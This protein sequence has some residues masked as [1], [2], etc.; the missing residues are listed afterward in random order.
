MSQQSLLP[1]P[2]RGRIL[3]SA[4]RADLKCRCLN[5]HRGG[6]WESFVCALTE[7]PL[8][9]VGEREIARGLEGISVFV[10]IVRNGYSRETIQEDASGGFRFCSK[11]VALED[12]CRAAELN[13]R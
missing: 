11:E 12:E 2:L 9:W 13:V 5:L 8:V 10:D 6:L 4:H 1:A 3:L 7:I